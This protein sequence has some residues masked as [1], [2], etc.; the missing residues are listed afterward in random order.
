MENT[1]WNDNG[2]YQ[3]EYEQM[4]ND[5]V[6]ASGKCDTLAGEMVRAAQ[7][8]GYDFYNNGMGNNTSGALNFLQ[9]Q[10]V[11]DRE[12]YD[13][14]YKFTRGRIYNGSYDGDDLQEAIERLMDQTIGL[15]IR[16]P[17][18]MTIENGEDMFDYEDEEQNF[19]DECGDE[20][21]HGYGYLCYYCEQSME[22]D[23]EEYA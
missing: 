4:S 7:R 21:E 19:C 1:Y 11:T 16:N 12:T 10:S 14:I 5:L 2:L 18:L 20:T 9:S 3:E 13:T 17:Q 15:I 23:D 6:P 22:E 8:L